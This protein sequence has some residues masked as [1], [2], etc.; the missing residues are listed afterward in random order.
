MGVCV[1]LCTHKH[2]LLY[3]VCIYCLFVIILN[4]PL[5]T[6]GLP[7]LRCLVVGNQK[8]EN[9]GISINSF[10]MITYSIC[11][12]SLETSHKVLYRLRINDFVRPRHEFKYSNSHVVIENSRTVVFRYRISLSSIHVKGNYS[13]SMRTLVK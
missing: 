6:C 3:I 10:K 4:I 1:C 9:I 13:S 11:K 8:L 7:V 12:T 2:T 5:Y